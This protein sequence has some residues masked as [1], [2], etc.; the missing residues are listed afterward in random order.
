[1]TRRG[2]EDLTHYNER[3]DAHLAYQR[4]MWL[5]LRS[6]LA[7]RPGW[8]FVADEYEEPGWCFGLDGACRLFLSVRGDS[9]SLFDAD[10][11]ESHTASAQ[12]LEQ[13][14][15]QLEP[16]HVARRQA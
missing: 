6:L 12:D 1:M 5:A 11:E 4:Q 10:N 8:Y 9:Y 2:R 7:D 16:T 15:N 13:L 3:I 14:L